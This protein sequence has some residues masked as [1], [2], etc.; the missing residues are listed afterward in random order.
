M[1]LSRIRTHQSD[2]FKVAEIIFFR[3]DVMFILWR[4]ES[5]WFGARASSSPNSNDVLQALL[6]ITH[7]V[8][9]LF[10]NSLFALKTYLK[11]KK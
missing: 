2:Y 9:S 10:I 8:L 11:S 1:D 4:S 3:D 5:N 7:G 6:L